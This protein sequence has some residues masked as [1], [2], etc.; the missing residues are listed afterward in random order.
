MKDDEMV[1][2]YARAGERSPGVIPI[3]QLAERVVVA[4]PRPSILRTNTA[5]AGAG[6]GRTRESTSCPPPRR[7]SQRTSNGSCRCRAG[8]AVWSQ[9]HRV[10]F[11]ARS[12]PAWAFA[13]ES[14][15]HDRRR[16]AGDCYGDNVL[17]GLDA[18]L[19]DGSY[20]K[21]MVMGTWLGSWS[22]W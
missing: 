13:D 17:A 6:F 5:P 21:Q 2:H 19:A 14:F 20:V 3:G 15:R 16:D 8:G 18:V 1:A 22:R 10:R 12:C 7:L 4:L 11:I 9:R